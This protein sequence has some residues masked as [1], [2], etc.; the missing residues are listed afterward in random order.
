MGF[1]PVLAALCATKTE[2][3]WERVGPWPHAARSSR[4][5]GKIHIRLRMRPFRTVW[6][7][8]RQLPRPAWVLFA[9]TFINRFGGFVLPFLVLYLTKR[10][11]TAT[12]AGAALSLYGVGSMGANFFGGHLADRV[13]RRNTIALSM[14]SSA[15]T[16]LTLSQMTRLAPILA[17]TFLAGVTAELYRP[18]AAAL[19]A[20]LTPN[21]ER[22]TAYA[23]YR[24]A[25]NAGFAAGPAVAGLVA[26][27]WF[28]FLF[29]VD[30]LTSV[31]YGI[32]V[33]TWLSRESRPN[34]RRTSARDLSAFRLVL[35][36]RRFATLLIAS[37]IISFV[38]QQGYAT[39]PLHVRASGH[40]T[41][42]YGELMSLNG[43]LIIVLELWLT[44]VTRRFAPRV[45][46]AV[47]LLLIGVGFGVTGFAHTATAMAATVVVWTLGEM[48]FSPVASAYVADIAPE[49]M[50]GRYQGLFAL[51]FSFG[52]VLAPI[53]G[54]ALLGID[55]RLLWGVCLA[56]GV[57][58]AT[59]VTA[60]ARRA[61]APA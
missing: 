60:N 35:A 18:A 20:D 50:R 17:L 51:T 21:G 48:C 27:R 45:A 8:V 10:G 37:A 40:S 19:I 32:I 24:L 49:D 13:G 2:S 54:T 43:G 3:C 61:I 38:F 58:A 33:L 5:A 52:M 1:A 9:G 59:L 30:A 41:T 4:R 56:L 7:D 11:Y 57:F 53:G 46:I 15:A 6:S 22:V 29:V 42:L 39:F 36:D 34:V 31:I 23:L 16:L 25:V 47:G 28:L 55:P 12:Q 44:G 14:F 26:E